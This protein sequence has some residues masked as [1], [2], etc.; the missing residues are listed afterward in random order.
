MN[1][2]RTKTYVTLDTEWN[3]TLGAWETAFAVEGVGAD[4]NGFTTPVFSALVA[5]AFVARQIMLGFEAFAWDGGGI[6]M[7]SD[8][9]DIEG[10]ILPD[11][12]LNFDFGQAGLCFVTVNADDNVIRKI[13]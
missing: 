11:D 1:D 4:W 5:S 10:W 12:D 2:L 7:T 6:M 3:D 13:G 9:G 8:T